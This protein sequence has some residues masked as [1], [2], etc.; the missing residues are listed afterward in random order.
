MIATNRMKKYFLLLTLSCLIS[1]AD[2]SK[3][4]FESGK[5]A[6]DSGKFDRARDYFLK[7]DSVSQWSGPASAYIRKIDSLSAIS[8]TLQTPSKEITRVNEQSIEDNLQLDTSQFQ[9]IDQTCALFLK[10]PAERKRQ[11][12]RFAATEDSIKE[13]TQKY[14]SSERSDEDEEGFNDDGMWYQSKYEEQFETLKE[15]G[16]PTVR[17]QDKEYIKLIDKDKKVFTLISKDAFLEDGM[18]LFH[19]NKKPLQLNLTD[20]GSEE[21]RKYFKN[22]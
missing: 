17:V 4:S 7:V 18:V 2:T 9:L 10:T 6:Y 1:C 13:T 22:E 12:E 16:I 19:I 5:N 21:I 11:N 14:D 20:W 3:D 8:S 15:L